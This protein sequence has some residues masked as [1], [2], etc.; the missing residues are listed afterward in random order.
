MSTIASFALG[1][2]S[3][4]VATWILVLQ[5][6]TRYR[7]RFQPVLQQIRSLAAQV[8]KSGYQFDH[9]VA[10]GRNSGV[11]G[12]ILAGQFGLTAVV[13]VSTSKVRQADGRRTLALDLV[14]KAALGALSGER[15]LV[16]I[17]CNDSG[18]TLEAVANYLEQLPS[19][20][21]DM[22]TAALYTAPSPSFMANF[23]AVVLEKDARY[24][25]SKVL[26]GL[27]WVTDEWLHP[28][29]GE[30]DRNGRSIGM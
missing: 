13:S 7:L 14:S 27:P 25:M 10:I 19:P 5:Q 23:N 22:K 8:R 30:R 9:I 12:S 28:L 2:I 26:N 1:V 18:S 16:F 20:P 17:C 24:S 15:L 21:V 6:R 29:A 11:A 3:S 4:L